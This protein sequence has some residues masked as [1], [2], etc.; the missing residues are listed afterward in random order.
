MGTRGEDL[1]TTKQQE[2]VFHKNYCHLYG[3]S[4]Y[5]YKLQNFG[6]S[7]SQPTVT[8]VTLA[9]VSFHF[10]FSCFFCLHFLFIYFHVFFASK[11][12][13]IPAKPKSVSAIKNNSGRLEICI[14]NQKRNSVNQ[15]MNKIT[16]TKK[17]SKT[18]TKNQQI[19]QWSLLHSV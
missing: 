13:I 1:R 10:Y 7:V 18:K 4:D 3:R 19:C 17:Q 15:K 6:W 8:L 5:F 9:S 16:T 12:K 11:E 14:C 2:G